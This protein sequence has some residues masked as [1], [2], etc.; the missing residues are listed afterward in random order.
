MMIIIIIMMMIIIIIMIIT[1]YHR[2][3]NSTSDGCLELS[4]AA[5]IRSLW[6]ICFLITS[7]ITERL[8]VITSCNIS[9]EL[10]PLGGSV[11]SWKALVW[12]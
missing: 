4:N 2:K 6:E 7:V 5:P 1:R 3:E 12:L 10:S 8:F 11:L 9:L